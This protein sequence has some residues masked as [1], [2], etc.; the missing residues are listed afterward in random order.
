MSSTSFRY[1]A[2]R[3]DGA[4]ES[5]LL[6]ALNRTEAAAALSRRGLFPLVLATDGMA[7]EAGAR[8]PQQDIALGL[9][10]LADLL[11]AG[12]PMGRALGAFEGVAP[13]SWR[14]G[15]PALRAALREGHSLSSALRVA[16]VTL[17]EA[18][19]GVLEAGE[20]GSG[21][22]PAL[23]RAAE[24][25]QTAQQTRSAIWAALVYPC[26]LAVVGCASLA[27]LVGV[28]LP[29]FALILADLGQSLP[30]STRLVL[31]AGAAA[32]GALYPALICAAFAAAA[33]GTWIRRPRSAERWSRWLQELPL[34]GVIRHSLATSRCADALAALLEAGVPL[35]RALSLA[36]RA[37]GD[38][39]V[40]ASLLSVREAVL[41]G[42][43][44]SSA[45]ASV[46]ALTDMAVR[47]VRVGE[48]TGNLARMLGQ[49]ARLERERGQAML[50][51]TVRVIEP[52]FILLFGALVALAAAALLQALYGLR[53][54]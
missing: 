6:N 37:A 31:Q 48:E 46:R 16:S 14:R 20:G 33:W 17:P 39:G 5:G 2:A 26:I 42:V 23:A 7:A 1:R 44:L 13:P 47:F 12:L 15:L 34:I 40:Q 45:L 50:R 51:A 9:R 36:G 52:A 41:Q 28:V 3:S 29:R 10:I 22:A 24:L 18:M 38:P 11:G 25:A 49:A 27:L 35:P 32:R 21:L 54:A 19:A 53:P 4:V 8:I 43:P 30:G